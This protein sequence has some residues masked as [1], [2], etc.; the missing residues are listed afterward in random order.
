MMTKI[1]VFTPTWL[2]EAGEPVIRPECR[3]SVEAQQFDGVIEWE[4]GTYNPW[5]GR[6]MR[7]V[8]AQYQRGRA[9]FLAGDGDAW[10]TFEHDMVLPDADAVQRLWNTMQKTGA[11]VVYGVYMLRHG[12]W[13]LNAWEYIGDH[14][15][16]ESLTLY[17]AKLARAQAQGVARVAG[18]GWGCTLIRRDVVERF[19]V[20]EGDGAGDLPFA[21]DCLL[22]GVVAVADFGVACDHWDGELRLRAFGGAM[23]DR[24][25][26]KALQDVVVMDGRGSRVLERGKEYELGRV[27]VDD[28]MRAGYVTEVEISAAEG[29]D[30][31]G[32][33][34]YAAVEAPER[35][36]VGKGRRKRVGGGL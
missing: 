2:N 9:S 10:L 14:A 28:L 22:G 34:E 13:V 11:G 35:A 31:K 1:V 8:V 23:Q 21:L 26:V 5:P 20:R 7:N 27:L 4:I 6:Q 16:G 30:K 25:K 18:V 24:V 29:P 15:M 32:E 12:A 3:A 33:G 19:P 36:V 17:P